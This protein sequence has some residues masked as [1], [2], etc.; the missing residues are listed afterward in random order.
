MTPW[1]DRLVQQLI[2]KAADTPNSYSGIY[3]LGRF[4]FHT[5][6]AHWCEPPRYL[7]LRCMK[8][9]AKVPT[10]L[11]DGRILVREAS[12]DLLVRAL[13]KPRRPHNGAVPLLRLYEATETGDRLRW[14]EA[15]LQ[16]A[17]KVGRLAMQCVRECLARIKPQS[18]SLTLLGDT[19]LI[20]NWMMLHAR[21]PI[22]PGCEDR[23]IAHC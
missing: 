14:D 8:G 4:P 10:L 2:P 13:V 20:D 23:R 11:V 6:L 22:P 21:S 5:D 12:R 15:F 9:Y 19:I 17:G 3:G 7:M 16:P 1:E 18:I